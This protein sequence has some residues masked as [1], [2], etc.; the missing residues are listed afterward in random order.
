MPK[1]APRRQTSAA[2]APRDAPRAP[3]AA[4]ERGIAVLRALAE[5]P[6]PLTHGELAAR[7]GISKPTLT[8][9]LGTLAS[10]ALVAGTDRYRL[11]SGVLAL[12]RAFLAG[13]DF[14]AVA[15]PHMAAL[16]AATE[17]WVYLGVP[18]GDEIVL[19]EICRSPANVLLSR[20]E[21]GSR[22]AVADTALGRAVLAAAPPAQRSRVAATLAPRAAKALKAALAAVERDGYASS[23]GDWHR[24][25][26]TVAC[27]IRGPRGEVL[28]L[29]CGGPAF[30]FPE[31]KLR[32]RV[33][34]ALLDCAAAIARDLGGAL[35]VRPPG[36]FGFATSGT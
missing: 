10:N 19:V 29:N 26:H 13:L 34:P 6:A 30:A 1:A 11:G 15:R 4:L 25:I 36:A 8:R 35:G 17:G 7:T 22:L 23:F 16:A 24:D 5:E 20:L 27:A 3:V 12:G 28:A 32:E 33:A 18:T 9:V 2:R 31:R 21:V 14:R